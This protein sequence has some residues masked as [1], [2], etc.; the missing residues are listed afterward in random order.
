[1]VP[2]SAFST[3]SWETGPITLSRF[4][5]RAAYEIDGEAG[6]GASSGDALKEIVALQKAVAPQ[7]GYAWSGLSRQEAQASGQA[8]LLYG[9]SVLMVFL[10]L[11]A[12]YESWSAPLA[13]LLAVPLGVVG[14]VLAVTLHGVSNSVYF[15]VGLLTTIGLAAKNA[16]LIVEFAEHALR[17][18]EDLVQAALE[19]ARL[20]LRPV[21]MTSLAL[22]AGILPLAVATGAG[23]QSRIA[24]GTSVAGGVLSATLLSVFYVPL[25][26]VGVQRLFQRLRA[27]R[28]EAA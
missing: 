27:R 10:C 13:V 4:A 9:L 16:I 22:V 25:F 2:F 12:L 18:G 19:A 26:F 5:G 3:T 20:R 8:P 11:A 14:A 6:P 23:A 17:S 15:Q 28:L 7:L 24:I 21:L 1:M